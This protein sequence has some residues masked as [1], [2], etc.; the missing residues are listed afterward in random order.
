M[1]N[2]RQRVVETLEP[3]FP[4]LLN[5]DIKKCVLRRGTLEQEC[6]EAELF[7]NCLN[8]LLLVVASRDK[9]AK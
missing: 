1:D 8:D 6:N 2:L 3:M 7:E 5:D 9:D 4:N